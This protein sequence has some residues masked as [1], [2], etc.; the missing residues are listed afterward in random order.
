MQILISFFQNNFTP[1]FDPTIINSIAQ[2]KN[3]GVILHSLLSLTFTFIPSAIP[4]CSTQVNSLNPSI[5]LNL[6]CNQPSQ[7]D[8]H[9]L[10]GV[11][12]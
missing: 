1:C 5:L 9:F 3:L 10:S 12:D 11:M 4:I 2:V 7:R 6:H 8:H